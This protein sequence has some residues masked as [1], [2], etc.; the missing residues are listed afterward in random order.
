MIL[1]DATL[2]WSG[3]EAQRHSTGLVTV[4]SLDTDARRA[5]L[6]W[7]AEHLPHTAERLVAAPA[8]LGGALVVTLNALL[9]VN[10]ATRLALPCNALA[11][12]DAARFTLLPASSSVP[13]FNLGA[14][15]GTFIARTAALLSLQ[16]GALLVVRVDVNG[17]TACGFS[18]R[19]LGRAPHA[20]AVVS[21]PNHLVFVASRVASS[22]LLHVKPLSAS[23][24][25][26]HTCI[27]TK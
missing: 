3:R 24:R 13:A 2:T 18:L 14:A 8:G 5:P 22:L 1:H 25:H 11:H 23:E 16:S 4:V 20:A 17:T 6:V 21:L 9:Y 19:H 12:V 10:Q 26:I 27:H 15:R 7:R